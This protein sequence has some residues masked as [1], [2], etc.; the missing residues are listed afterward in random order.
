M[1]ITA[2][3]TAEPKLRK[4]WLMPDAWPRISSGSRFS[5]SVPSGESTRPNPA[6]VSIIPTVVSLPIWAMR[7]ISCAQTII[8]MVPSTN[9]SVTGRLAPELVHPATADPRGHEV[10]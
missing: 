7:S 4:V 9:P 2:T 1:P 3:P 10:P 5:A 8:P 6:P